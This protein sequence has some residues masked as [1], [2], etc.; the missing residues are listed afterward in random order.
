MYLFGWSSETFVVAVVCADCTETSIPSSCEI[1]RGSP[2]RHD[3]ISRLQSWLAV[4]VSLL[5]VGLEKR[6]ATFRPILRWCASARSSPVCS[7]SYCCP[8]LFWRTIP[9]RSTETQYIYSVGFAVYLTGQ[10]RRAFCRQPPIFLVVSADQ[11][12]PHRGL[13]RLLTIVAI[14][15]KP[16]GRE[17]DR[18][19]RATRWKPEDE[20]RVLST[21]QGYNDSLM[22]MAKK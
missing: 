4:L 6:P 16:G 8:W 19:A 10:D 11:Q 1:W 14:H 9:F 2:A 22:R 21:L 17:E 12:Y 15:V 3:A 13:L 20:K 7:S 5:L 18:A